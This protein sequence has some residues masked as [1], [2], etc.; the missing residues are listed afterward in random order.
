MEIRVKVK[1]ANELARNLSN[2][3]GQFP[4]F[5]R[6]ALTKSVIKLQKE[7]KHEAKGSR[8]TGTLIRNIK[9]S[10]K[11]LRGEV[12]SGAKHSVFV[13]EG[14]RPHMP[15]IAPL[16]AWAARKLGSPGLGFVIA[17][18]IAREGT[19]AQPFM[20]PAVD[21]SENAILGYFEKEIANLV[22]EMAK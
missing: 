4:V 6:R 8:D 17:R 14:T 11:G 20:Q 3:K 5:M 15:P 18:K 1:G 12:V 7:A 10:V 19:E 16:E 9:R 22:N 13:E 2:A 21:S